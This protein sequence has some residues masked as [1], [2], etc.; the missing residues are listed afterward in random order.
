MVAKQLRHCV[1]L[2]Y[3]CGLYS[4]VTRQQ[5][6]HLICAFPY[7]A[8]DKVWKLIVSIPDLCI[9][10]YFKHTFLKYRMYLII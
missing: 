6:T 3:L 8:L 7:G 9:I 2:D 1:K 5:G 10:P 4:Y